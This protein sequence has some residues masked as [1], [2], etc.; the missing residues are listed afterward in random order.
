MKVGGGQE[1]GVV[2]IEEGESCHGRR[3]MVKGGS[4]VEREARRL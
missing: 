2:E 4:V 1:E 3:V